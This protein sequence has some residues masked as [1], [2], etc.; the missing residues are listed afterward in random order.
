MNLQSEEH[1]VGTPLDPLGSLKT[2]QP[3][4]GQWRSGRTHHC[5]TCKEGII[6]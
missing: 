2:S 3:C 6:L 5:S 4:P 1:G